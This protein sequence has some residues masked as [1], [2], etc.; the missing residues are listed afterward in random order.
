MI[1]RIKSNKTFAVAVPLLLL[2]AFATAAAIGTG[3]A[4]NVR[5]WDGEGFGPGWHGGGWFHHWGWFHHFGGC[6]DQGID[7]YQQQNNLAYSPVGCATC[8][9]GY[10]HQTDQTVKQ[11]TSINV[12]NSPGATVST[13]QES[14]QQM[15]PLQHLVQGLCTITGVNC[16]Q[17]PQPYQEQQ[18]EQP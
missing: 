18:E 10:Q 2:L 9:E 13:N 16:A 15:A 1:Q 11:G 17:A 8:G 5:A 6:C 12:V 3:Q 4:G 14:S 7:G